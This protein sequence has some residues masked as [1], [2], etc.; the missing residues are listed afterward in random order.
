MSKAKKMK[1]FYLRKK[2]TLSLPLFSNHSPD[3]FLYH[4]TFSNNNNNFVIITFSNNNS[5]NNN[6]NENNTNF[7]IIIIII[8]L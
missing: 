3:L 6:N 7:L 2:Q 8:I 5:N 4:P 1:T